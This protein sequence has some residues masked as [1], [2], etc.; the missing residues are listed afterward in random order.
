MPGNSQKAGGVKEAATSQELVS[1]VITE[2]LLKLK[3]FSL[4]IF[5]ILS[6]DLFLYMLTMVICSRHL[7][8]LL[9]LNFLC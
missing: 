9:I 1:G 5:I 3:G 2:K 6:V 8:Y 4:S 7:L